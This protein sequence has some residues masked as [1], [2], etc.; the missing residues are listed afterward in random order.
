MTI[1]KI[2]STKTNMTIMTTMIIMTIIN[3]RIK[4]IK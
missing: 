3:D 2:M 1:M 4:K